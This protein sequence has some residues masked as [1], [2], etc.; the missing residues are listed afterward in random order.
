MK[1]LIEA[2]G[3]RVWAEVQEGLAVYMEL[4]KECENDGRSEADID[5]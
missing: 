3:G 5:R 2:M 1:Y 4:S